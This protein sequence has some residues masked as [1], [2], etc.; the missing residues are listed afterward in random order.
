MEFPT[1]FK[2]FLINMF[3]INRYTNT[4]NVFVSNPS[5]IRYLDSR[6]V[7]IMNKT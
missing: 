5:E 4:D 2:D 1:I 6:N 7:K 3:I